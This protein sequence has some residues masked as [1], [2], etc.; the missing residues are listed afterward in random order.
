MIEAVEFEELVVL[1]VHDGEMGAV[2]LVETEDVVIDVEVCHVHGPVWRIG[3][4][5]DDDLRASLVH[6]TGDFLDRVDGAQNVR[7]VRH[8]DKLGALGHQAVERIQVDLVPLA[9]DAPFLDDDA[10]LF[11][12][13]PGADVRLVVEVGHH[14]LVTRL[15][16]ALHGA[17]EELAQ[18]RGRGAEN[19]FL[20]TAR[21]EKS[22]DLRARLE[23]PV[24]GA[25]RVLVAGA[26]LHAGRQKIIGDSP[27]HCAERASRPHCRNRRIRPQGPETVSEQ[28]QDR[29]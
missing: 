7:G 25:L 11:Q 10:A 24:G 27:R 16:V 8:G 15:E 21:V 26:R 19:D 12:R 17:G 4:R 23:K 14:D 18:D 28:R 22:R 3:Y 6:A 20:G 5:I 9:L 13:T 29:E 2:G 1:A